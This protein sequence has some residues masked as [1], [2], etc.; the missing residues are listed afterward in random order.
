MN[1]FKPLFI[2]FIFILLGNLGYGQKRAKQKK[3][4]IEINSPS[5]TKVTAV[6]AFCSAKLSIKD[7]LQIISKGFCWSLEKNPTIN[8][9]KLVLDGKSSLLEGK[10]IGLIPGSKYYVKAFVTVGNRT[11][12]SAETL[13]VTQSLA[14]NSN[15][16][17]GNPSFSEPITSCD[18]N[19][20]MVKPQY[21]LSYNNKKR[22]PNWVSWHLSKEYIGE[23][24]RNDDFRGDAE[25]PFGWVKVVPDYYAKSGFDKGHMCPSAD[26]TRNT[27]DNSATFLM[28][29]MVPQAPK[30]NRVTWNQLEAYSRKLVSVGNE[31]Y[32]VSGIFGK[33]G[34]GANGYA[35][36][37][38]NGVEVP[39]SLWKVIA[40][41]PNGDNDIERINGSTR[42]V[43]VLIPNNQDCSS[44]PW[45][46]YRVSVDSIE[47]ITGYDFFSN[48]SDSIQVII[49]PVVD[50]LRVD[51]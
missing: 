33:G 31:L 39:A 23:A 24:E 37:I 17:M 40:I 35:E 3:I 11:I 4:Q 21:T 12:Y 15:I 26:R 10:L 36:Y 1:I 20:L 49:E 22:I 48:I 32:I 46:S 14:D 6:S 41:I 2:V 5:I 28:T 50:T 38:G 16:L 44:K 45:H 18:S 30:N 9:S 25:I 43:A 47:S 7:S 29:N 27:T 8:S 13:L 51:D 19:Y 34:Y 42:V